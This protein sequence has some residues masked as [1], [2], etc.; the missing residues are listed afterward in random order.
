LAKKADAVKVLDISRITSLADYF[1]ICSG[2][3]V[4]RTEALSQVIE[5]DMDGRGYKTWHREGV[6]AGT[7][8]VLDYTDVVVHILYEPIRKFYDLDRLWG[9]ADLV[10]LDE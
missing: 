3:S 4:R 9:D 2:T 7:W 8:I 10:K 5:E 1:V 6:R